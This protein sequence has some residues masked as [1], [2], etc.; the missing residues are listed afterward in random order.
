MIFQLFLG[1]YWFTKHM[2]GYQDGS[3]DFV[4]KF[5]LSSIHLVLSICSSCKLCFLLLCLPYKALSLCQQLSIDCVKIHFQSCFSLNN[6]KLVKDFNFSDVQPWNIHSR[7]NKS[8]SQC[9][10]IW[11]QLFWDMYIFSFYDFQR[12]SFKGW[13]IKLFGLLF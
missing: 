2:H 13:N 11:S 1:T 4:F 6:P 3:R 5:D 9:F 8:F 7:F 10:L 12:S